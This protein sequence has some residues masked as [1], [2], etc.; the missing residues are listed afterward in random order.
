MTDKLNQAIT[1]RLLTKSWSGAKTD[2]QAS[3]EVLDSHAA[4]RDSGRFIKQMVDKTAI[5]AITKVQQRARST[6]NGMS[7]PWADG[8]RLISP[9][10]FQDWA[11][12]F[13]VIEE[14]FRHAIDDLVANYTALKQQARHKLGTLFKE[15]DYPSVEELRGMFDLD[16]STMLI[17]LD[18][19]ASGVLSDFRD[20]VAAK[21]E[22]AL[23]TAAAEAARSGIKRLVE[24][25][26]KLHD[27]AKAYD[28][29][30]LKV[31]R[32]G[33]FKAIGEATEAIE[34]LAQLGGDVDVIEAARKARADLEE[35]TP[36]KLKSYP[37]EVAEATGSVLADLTPY[38]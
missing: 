31:V 8:S 9:V 1:V 20:A 5:A 25:V 16:Y 4:A 3:K 32:S 30:Q 21:A 24:A 26:Q 38:M 17:S 14:D 2:K 18:T 11:S 37:T 36:E 35:F 33:P 7:L 19:D 28:E 12:Q 23:R 10:K 22:G 13:R 6:L 29:G 15:E 34:A 27:N